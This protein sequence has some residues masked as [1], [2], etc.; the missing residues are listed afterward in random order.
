MLS[1][2]D[3]SDSSDVENVSVES[4]TPMPNNITVPKDESSESIALHLPVAYDETPRQIAICNDDY[5][6]AAFSHS[7]LQ[8]FVVTNEVSGMIHPE[9]VMTLHNQ[10]TCSYTLLKNDFITYEMVSHEILVLA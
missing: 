2:E 4:S 10:C 7:I 1:L 8:E 9:I 3:T 5:K 6:F